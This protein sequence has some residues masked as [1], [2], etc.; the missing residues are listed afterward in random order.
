MISNNESIEDGNAR[1][2][3]IIITENKLKLYEDSYL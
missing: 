2:R 3:T 1:K